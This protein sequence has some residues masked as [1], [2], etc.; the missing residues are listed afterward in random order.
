M[1]VKERLKELVL[2]LDVKQYQFAKSIGVSSATVSDWLNTTN[3]NPSIESLVRISESH[4]INLQWLLTGTGSMYIERP[5]PREGS[6][7]SDRIITLPVVAD[8]AAGIG[9]EAEEI[10]PTEFL[11]IPAAILEHP[12]PYYCFRVSGTSMEPEFH[13]GDYA[14]IS[15]YSFAEDYNGCICAFRSV[16]GL[17]L[18]RLVHDHRGKRAL[19][20]PINP[21]HPIQIYDENSPEII[22]IGRL[23]AII[24]KY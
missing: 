22:L 20:V 15:A 19:L 4:N 18:K 23:A 9:I 3:V 1:T 5:R 14:I 6:P 8:I 11:P 12:G 10:E 2:K 7:V 17:L 24:R 21:T 13:T 16:D